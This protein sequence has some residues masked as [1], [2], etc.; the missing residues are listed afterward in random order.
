MSLNIPFV[1]ETTPRQLVPG[2]QLLEARRCVHFQGSKCRGRILVCLDHYPLTQRRIS[3][4]GNAQLSCLLWQTSLS[5]VPHGLRPRSV[6][7]RLR[8]P[9]PPGA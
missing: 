3:E 4:D 8:V 1:W 9:I 7:V 2:S 6:D 5:Q